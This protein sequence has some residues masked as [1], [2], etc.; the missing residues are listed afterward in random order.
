MAVVHLILCCCIRRDGPR[1]ISLESASQLH[2]EIFEHSRYNSRRDLR[3][4][5]SRLVQDALSTALPSIVSNCA[6]GVDTLRVANA[7]STSEPKGIPELCISGALLRRLL[8]R[9][10]PPRCSRTL[11]LTSLWT[12][13]QPHSFLVLQ[14]Q[15]LDAR[16]HLTHHVG[17]NHALSSTIV[18]NA[19]AR[20]Q[21]LSSSVARQRVKPIRT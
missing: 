9:P 16:P 12:P 4:R 11:T 18:G 15:T 17:P 13:R 8:W 14:H 21:P 6:F 19:F 10:P 20:S 1:L 3:G 5:H 7:L 2:W